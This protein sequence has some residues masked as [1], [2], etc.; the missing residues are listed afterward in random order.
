[1]PEAGYRKT[2]GGRIEGAGMRDGSVGKWKRLGEKDSFD[3]KIFSLKRVEFESP[4]GKKALFT[5]A[6]S[7]DWAI[8]VA[9]TEKEGELHCVMVRQYRFGADAIFIEFPGGI[10]E[11]GEEPEAAVLREL[12]EET[13]YRAG[14]VVRAGRVSPNPAFLTNGLSVFVAT[15]LVRSGT[16]RRDEHEDMEVLLLPL[17]EVRRAMGEGQMANAVMCAGLFL[18]EKILSGGDSAHPWTQ[19]SPA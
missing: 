18:A 7:R 11:E 13:G 12:E 16:I 5:L 1:M 2:P 15:D 6:D 19:L 17:A 9:I 8:V 4:E 10:V 3:A 14:R